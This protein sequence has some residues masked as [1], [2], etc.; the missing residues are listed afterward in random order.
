ML[1]KFFDQMLM[2]LKAGPTIRIFLS[3]VL[4]TKNLLNK[5]ITLH[6]CNS[7]DRQADQLHECRCSILQNII[8]NIDQIQ[9]IVDKKLLK[10]VIYC[11][12]NR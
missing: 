1:N 2:L 3:Q 11:M 4:L 5:Y 7:D 10:M 9:K 6:D 8:R 12:E